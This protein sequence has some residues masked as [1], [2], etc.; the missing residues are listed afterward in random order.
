LHSHLTALKEKQKQE[1][2][3]RA[4][5]DVNQMQQDILNQSAMQIDERLQL[6]TAQ[7]IEPPLQN[8]FV[9]AEEQQE[10]TDEVQ[11]DIEKAF[12]PAVQEKEG[13]AGE[14]AELIARLQEQL[15]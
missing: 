2:Q 13:Q 3:R 1:Q 12:I 9:Q 7:A 10:T 5:L 15:M 6:K 4:E 14:Y 11:L 8:S